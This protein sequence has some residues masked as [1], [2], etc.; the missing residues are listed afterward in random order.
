MATK[1]GEAE[2]L[3]L[4]VVTILRAATGLEPRAPARSSS[5]SARFV[6]YAGTRPMA[7]YVFDEA[8]RAVCRHG[9]PA[10]NEEWRLVGEVIARMTAAAIKAA[11]LEGVL[12]EVEREGH[13]G[14][15]EDPGPLVKF[16]TSHILPTRLAD[17]DGRLIPQERKQRR[18]RYW[19]TLADWV[20][21]RALGEL[22]AEDADLE[23]VLE[24]PAERLGTRWHSASDSPVVRRLLEA[25]LAAVV[26]D[27]EGR[28]PATVRLVYSGV[29]IPAMCGQLEMLEIDGTIRSGR[30]VIGRLNPEEVNLADPQVVTSVRRDVHALGSKAGHKCI[31][32][33]ISRAYANVDAGAADPRLVEFSGGWSGLAQAIGVDQGSNDRLQS[34]ARAGQCVQWN[35]LDS[36]NLKTGGGLWLYSVQAA[37]RRGPAMLRFVVGE[38]LLPYLAR[39]MKK[40]EQGGGQ[41]ARMNRRLVPELRY[42]IPTGG[43]RPNEE[44]RVWTMAR[45]VVLH[46]VDHAPDLVREG[47][48]RLEAAGWQDLHEKAGLPWRTHQQVLEAWLEGEDGAPALL[49]ETERGRYTL[50]DEHRLER[51]FIESRGRR[52]IEER[53]K[54]RVPKVARMKRPPR[55]R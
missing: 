47:G 26:R 50:A 29:F 46:M 22:G 55:R 1:S 2:E 40:G 12:E 43:V 38:A 31:R 19:L 5:R 21:V 34:I 6:V 9:T 53:A 44:G 54:V 20:Y 7:R 45:L 8:C 13:V 28:R 24:T 39:L 49:L 32:E 17:S 14:D 52:Q 11:R 36:L 18:K 35:A 16:R 10:T 33:L 15:P 25:A 23:R 48:V 4:P 30:R 3:E 51:I 27:A 37:S 41:T 42:D